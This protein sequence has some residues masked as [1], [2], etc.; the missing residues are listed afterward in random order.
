MTALLY[1]A[2]LQRQL[3]LWTGVGLAVGIVGLTIAFATNGGAVPVILLVVIG[4]VVGG[5]AFAMRLELG[6]PR[7]DGRAL[8]TTQVVDE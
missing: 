3:I 2:K 5:I 4:L 6:A 8:A 1:V 7:Q